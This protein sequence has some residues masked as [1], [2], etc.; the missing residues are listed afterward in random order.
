[1]TFMGFGVTTDLSATEFEKAS[2]QY[3]NKRPFSFYYPYSYQYYYPR[4][5]G[6]TRTK[7]C[8]WVYTNGSYIYSCK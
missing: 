4:S 1:M 7:A 3:G 6:Y 2:V 8:H 5:K